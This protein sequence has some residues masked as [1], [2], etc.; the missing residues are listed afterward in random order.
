MLKNDTFT[1]VA[2]QDYI[3]DGLA[4][5]KSLYDEGLLDTAAFTQPLEQ[6]MTIGNNSEII[7]GSYSAGHLAMAVSNMDGPRAAVY[8][9]IPP[10]R[11]PNG[12]RGLPSSSGYPRP[13]AGEFIITDKA[14]NPALAIK[15]ADAWHN[16]QRELPGRFGPK[17]KAW[18]DADPGTFGWDG[19]TPAVYKL[20][21]V[22]WG[23]SGY[24]ETLNFRLMQSVAD[25][26]NQIVGPLTD[27]ANYGSR[28]EYAYHKNAAYAADVQQVPN[29]TYSTDITARQ[30]Q[31]QAPLQDFV[32][33]SIVEF[34]TGRAN[35][36]TGW[37]T[38]KQSLEQLGYSEYIRNMQAAYN[39]QKN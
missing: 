7:L 28:M 8:D 4:Y 29:L 35:L 31:L 33:A 26:H 34:V 30:A 37:E 17:G 38:Y 12:Y 11:G 5:I 25:L 19:K 23:A 10:L 3:R 21:S 22:D 16:T 6:L 27:P 9:N 15:W 2:N 20:L 14:K 24:T 1:P 13:T 32:K 18:V 36:T 39:A